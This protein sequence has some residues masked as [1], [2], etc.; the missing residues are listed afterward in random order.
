MVY[1]GLK[2][3]NCHD[4]N[5]EDGLVIIV[6]DKIKQFAREEF[7]YGRPEVR[8]SAEKIVLEA[9]AGKSLQG[10]FSIS[11]SEKQAMQGAVYVKG[12][13]FRIPQNLFLGASNEILYEFDASHLKP[14]TREKGML[15][16]VSDLGEL[17]LPYEAKVISPYCDTVLGKIR[18]LYHFANLA[19]IQWKEA[20]RLFLSPEFP[21]ILLR[22]ERQKLLYENLLKSRSMNLAMEEFLIAVHKKTRV[23]LTLSKTYVCYEN[24]SEISRD[25]VEVLKDGW[26]YGEY[27]AEAEGDFIS[28]ERESFTTGDF[29]GNAYVLNYF[30]H[31]ERMHPGKNMGS[32]RV[33][34]LGGELRFAITAMGESH[35]EELLKHRAKRQTVMECCQN[36]LAL[37]LGKMTKEAYEGALKELIEEKGSFPPYLRELFMV[38]LEL[39]KGDEEKAREGLESLKESLS[40]VK[41]TKALEA[42]GAYYYL[43]AIC[44]KK[45]ADIKK[46]SKEI[47]KLKK[48]KKRQG[49]LWWFMFYL[50]T[51]FE[52]HGEE[53]I[54]QVCSYI[55]Q[56]A[57]VSPML[58]LEAVEAVNANPEVLDAPSKEWEK[59]LSWGI[60]H[61][62][63]GKETALRYAFLCQDGTHANAKL[64]MGLYPKYPFDEI[65]EPLVRA[66]I[67]ENQ[68]DASAF[69]WYDKGVQH[70]LRVENMFEYYLYARPEDH[71]EK[72]P[73]PV[74]TYF[75]Y[76]NHLEPETKAFLYAYI[77][78]HASR[79]MNSYLA[80]EKEIRQFTMERLYQGEISA[81]L[82]VLYHRFIDQEQLGDGRAVLVS[83]ILLKHRIRVEG[84]GFQ[85]VWI[86]HKEMEKPSVYPLLDGEC[87]GDI[88]TENAVCLVRD[89]IGSLYAASVEIKAEP[90]MQMPQLAMKCYEFCKTN[91]GL[92]LHLYEKILKYQKN[93]ESVVHIRR[94][95]ML[96]PGFRGVYQGECYVFLI[97]YYLEHMEIRQLNEML[98]IVEL[99]KVPELFR[100]KLAEYCIIYEQYAKAERI[101]FEYGF[102]GVSMHRLM[103][104]CKW[105]LE[106]VERSMPNQFL[107]KLCIYLFEAGKAEEPVLSYLM[108]NYEGGRSDLVKI[109]RAGK[110]LGMDIGEFEER[111]LGQMLFT[112]NYGKHSYEVFASFYERGRN[113]VLVKAFLAHNSY[114]YVVFDRNLPEYHFEVLAKEMARSDGTAGA[115]A[116]LKYY[117]GHSMELTEEEKA[118]AKEKLY[119]LTSRK[120]ILPFFKRFADCFPLPEAI[121]NRYYIEYR[122]QPKSQA[123]IHYY[124]DTGKGR[125]D[126]AESPMREVYWGIYICEFIL[127]ADEALQ[128]YITELAEE[129]EII[130]ESGRAELNDQEKAEGMERGYGLIN[131]MLTAREMQ[132]DKT[133]FELMEYY[134]KLNYAAETL[135]TPL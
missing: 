10:S 44:T 70:R 29:I 71:E 85:E 82:A 120:L 121:A 104:F 17:R 65:L 59:I 41:K 126:F 110:K 77:A 75:R 16:I 76:D 12:N 133:L 116:L 94:R 47:G 14:D 97:E 130:T 115:L 33:R 30:L 109:F 43:L 28:L 132:D 13:S 102:Q 64:L 113:P 48:E 11:N 18:D 119:A 123:T 21:A 25:F 67:R 107:L 15:F 124:L 8:L 39:V 99:E 4:A 129:E 95:L 31:P 1:Y 2:C 32:I 69:Y 114:K 86:A 128:Y 122:T 37:R 38:H 96:L 89:A 111:L 42:F 60:R 26:G 98:R 46:A 57:N 127:F 19:K 40:A 125:H 80:Y 49:I 91:T 66:L 55:A 22:D 53:R 118:F 112:E 62:I 61:E 56:F 72:I 36:Y 23:G 117:S 3:V 24:C 131:L 51:A 5:T 83:R 68:R 27:A 58:C 45:E 134:A 50:D 34:Y 35:K 63:V 78:E 84:E 52:E 7:N 74:L 101:L 87:Y 108:E 6:Q 20:K 81:S 9:E 103:R 54:R 73:V 100:P 88:C 106:T 92:L 105:Q 79:D 90:V 135:F 93:E